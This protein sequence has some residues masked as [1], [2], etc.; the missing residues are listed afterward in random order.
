MLCALSLVVT[1][2]SAHDEKSG[3]PRP[4]MAPPRALHSSKT[5][6][7]TGCLSSKGNIVCCRIRGAHALTLL[8]WLLGGPRGAPACRVGGREICCFPRVRWLSSFCG[9][10]C[11]CGNLCCPGPRSNLKASWASRRLGKTDALQR[12]R[13]CLQSPKKP[14][15]RRTS[16]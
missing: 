3:S 15:R 9:N 11:F 1:G 13:C 14:A 6:R 12:G 16:S 8:S 5:Q 4:L 2:D 7:Q 10:R